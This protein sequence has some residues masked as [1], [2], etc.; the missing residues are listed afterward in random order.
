MPSTPELILFAGPSL[1]RSLP[2]PEGATVL[3]PVRRGDLPALLRNRRPGALAIADGLFH[4]S[5]AVGHL[6][7]LWYGDRTLPLLRRLVMGRVSASARTDVEADFA[8]FDRFRIKV[9]DLEEF[10]GEEVWRRW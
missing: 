3:P 2:L 5:L 10:L 6:K 4:Q 1:P 7:N 9:R 8:S